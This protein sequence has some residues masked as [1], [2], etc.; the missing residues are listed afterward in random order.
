MPHSYPH[1]THLHSSRPLDRGELEGL[2]AL[3]ASLR[4]E[5]S[6]P[7]I[8][9]DSLGGARRRRLPSRGVR[10]AIEAAVGIALAGILL[11]LFGSLGRPP[12]G[13]TLHCPPG[14]SAAVAAI[15]GCA[16]QPDDEP[17]PG[18]EGGVRG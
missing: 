17:L 6:E 14:T 12:E 4:D 5:M 1:L 2:P 10:L 11:S 18:P 8:D 15:T 3:P 9:A 13:S 16:G 7:R